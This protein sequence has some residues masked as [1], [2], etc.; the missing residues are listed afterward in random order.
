MEDGKQ[1][2]LF[3][4]MGVL[5]EGEDIRARE[6][7]INPVHEDT[8]VSL[9]LSLS[10]RLSLDSS[11][12]TDMG[13]KRQEIHCKKSEGTTEKSN[14]GTDG[15]VSLQLSLSSD[16][17][18]T[19]TSKTDKGKQVIAYKQNVPNMMCMEK[20]SGVLSQEQTDMSLELSLAVNGSW[21]LEVG[22]SSNHQNLNKSCSITK[23]FDRDLTLA[24]TDGLTSHK[25]RKAM[26][27]P[28]HCATVN[29]KRRVKTESRRMNEL[30]V[31]HDPWCIKKRLTKSDLSDM[32]RLLL[33]TELVV[34]HILPHWD[35]DQ[36]TQIPQ[37]LKVWVFDC[38]TNS[39]HG[40]VFKQWNNGAYVLIS[41]WIPDFVKRRDLK[42]GDE[43]GLY[44]DIQN[45]R[46]NFSLLNRAPRD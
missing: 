31:W 21:G 45:S 34:S 6:I 30:R 7:N 16:N 18:S 5:G 33:S 23:D 25:K 1:L 35:E 13:K 3:D 15:G 9:D 28:K 27:N 4:F 46:F 32:S 43:I 14:A 24:L 36:E 41:K 10:L 20:N 22:E 8:H 44:W 11:A 39:E 42:Q 19:G 17:M 26:E 37:G 12:T 40:L 29:K 38:D 2:V